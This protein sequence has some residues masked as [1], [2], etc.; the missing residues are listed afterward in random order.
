M[1]DFSRPLDLNRVEVDIRSMID[2]CLA[3]VEENAKTQ[4][5]S[6]E[7]RSADDLPPML[8][9]PMRIRQVLVNLLTNAV[10]S[11]SEEYSVTIRKKQTR[12]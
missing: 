4:K 11:C 6:V 10:Q 1:L 2:E 3:I 9:D 7:A 5:V 12:A 8:V